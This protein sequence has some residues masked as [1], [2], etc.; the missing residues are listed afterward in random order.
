MNIE[1]EREREE[2]RGVD[3]VVVVGDDLMRGVSSKLRSHVI[4]AAEPIKRPGRTG[5]GLIEKDE[6]RVGHQLVGDV[7]SLALSAG[8]TTL[9]ISTPSPLVE[10]D[11]SPHIATENT[12]RDKK[13]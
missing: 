7:G 2:R 10:C 1:A 9:H 3:D 12:E 4:G 11:E 8:D 5:G 6:G 13:R